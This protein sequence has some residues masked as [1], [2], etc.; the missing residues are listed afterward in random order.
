MFGI[1]QGLRLA[2]V[3]VDAWPHT[4]SKPHMSA[5][6]LGVPH[7]T[8]IP[9]P[10]RPWS[11]AN[12]CYQLFVI[13]DCVCECGIFTCW[14]L[15]LL[16]LLGIAGRVSSHGDCNWLWLECDVERLCTCPPGFVVLVEMMKAKHDEIFI[17]VFV[18]LPRVPSIAV[19]LFTAS[20]GSAGEM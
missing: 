3:Y 4:G 19:T 9:Q 13:G 2:L 20:M 6:P 17:T 7:C 15:L 10:Q 16:P 1:V 11:A 18:L 8:R 12:V 14:Y 5:A